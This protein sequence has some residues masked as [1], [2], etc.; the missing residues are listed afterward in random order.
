MTRM[1]FVQ[2]LVKFISG[3]ILTALLLFLPAGTQ[4]Y[5]EGWLFMVILFAPMFIAGIVM[6]VKCPQLLAKRLNAKET[7]SAQKAVIGLSGGMFLAGFVLCGL[8]ARFGW[9][10]LPRW[11]VR[12]AAAVFL[13]SY[14]L[15]A[16]VLRENAHLSRTVE[17]QQGQKVIDRGLYGIV[18]H[19]MY[20]VTVPMFLSIPLILNAPAAF[21]IFLLHPLLLVKR[22][23]NEEAVL[24]KEL[25][26]YADYQKKVKFRLIPRIG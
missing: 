10:S 21:P 4:N 6:M 11:A 18:R 24:E 15:Y 2:A 5:P 13:I 1:L 22:I 8:N 23:R 16:E 26:G 14:G 7:Q 12:T 9:T 3:L 25:D 19:P 20:A 17:V